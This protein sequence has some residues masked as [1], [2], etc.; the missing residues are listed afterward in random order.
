MDIFG[1]LQTPPV[2]GHVALSGSGIRLFRTN[3][4]PFDAPGYSNIA[5]DFNR[6]WIYVQYKL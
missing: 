1:V 3:G 5:G 4:S 2:K 6:G